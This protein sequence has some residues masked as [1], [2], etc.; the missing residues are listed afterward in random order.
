MLA[1]FQS[2]RTWVLHSTSRSGIWSRVGISAVP[3]R[4]DDIVYHD[5]TEIIMA[6]TVQGP[7]CTRCGGTER[8][9]PSKGRQTG[10]CVVCKRGASGRRYATAESTDRTREAA[11]R[12]PSD[13]ENSRRNRL[14]SPRWSSQNRDAYREACRRWCR[15]NPEKAN[16]YNQR[17]RARKLRPC[18]TGS[19]RISTTRSRP[20]T[21]RL[22]G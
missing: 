2:R 21:P 11:R 9:S 17:R 19:P 14:S 6:E 18:P 20:S 4:H 13:P 10:A 5:R 15:E 16:A 7:P 8:Y 1:R 12:W 22:E 3:P